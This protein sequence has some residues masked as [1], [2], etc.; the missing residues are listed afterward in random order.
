MLTKEARR[1]HRLTSAGNVAFVCLFA[2]QAG[3]LTLGP[4]LPSVAHEFG[5]STAGAGQLRTIAGLAG[6]IAAITVMLAGRRIGLRKLLLAGNGLLGL[7]SLVS[8]AAPSL[9]VLAAAQMAVGAG[10]GLLI[11]GGLAA[12]ASWAPPEARARTLAWAS[13]GQPASWVAGVP[14]IGLTADLDWRYAWLGVPF[15]ASLAGLAAVLSRPR[16]R[17]AGAGEPRS[18]SLRLDAKLVGWGAGEV[19]AYAGWAGVL[20]YAGSLL[21]ESYDASPGT[22]G[23]ALGAAAIA[24]F[25]GN[26]LV[27]RWLAG[28]SRELL[29]VTGLLAAALTVVFGAVRPGFAVSAAIFAVLVLV[30]T[31]RTLAGSAFALYVTPERRLA[32]MGLRASTAQFGYLLGAA[33]GGA[34]LASGGYALLGIALAILFVLGATPHLAALLAGRAPRRRLELRVDATLPA[35]KAD[36]R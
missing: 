34:A 31:T 12:A 15:A 7:G 13:L 17:S 32:A 21:V 36:P 5:V 1:T 11:S 2:A 27:R 10:A 19:L 14:L 35:L 4:I 25:P 28:S 16:E 6:G 18:Y 33:F 20:V 24:A 9:A 3:L 23:L 29:V 8:A 22:V 26:L 30:A